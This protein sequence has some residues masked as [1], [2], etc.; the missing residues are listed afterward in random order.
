MKSAIIANLCQFAE[1]RTREWKDLD[2]LLLLGGGKPII[3][4]SA[5]ARYLHNACSGALPVRPNAISVGPNG[6]RKLPHDAPNFSRVKIARFSL[7]T[8]HQLWCRRKIPIRRRRHCRLVLIEAPKNILRTKAFSVERRI[9]T[10]ED[11][12]IDTKP[13]ETASAVKGSAVGFQ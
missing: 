10:F 5:Q 1:G 4:L 6:S 9:N 12:H 2:Q 11:C 13:V 3:R 8:S 7:C